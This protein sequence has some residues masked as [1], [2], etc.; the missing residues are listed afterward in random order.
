MDEM[1][2]GVCSSQ[3]LASIT[4][5]AVQERSCFLDQHRLEKH[6]SSVCQLHPRVT[7]HKHW[8]LGKKNT[9]HKNWNLEYLT[10]LIFL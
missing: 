3:A 1:L 8:I 5:N 6:F 10:I 2:Y 9:I 7:I 4:K